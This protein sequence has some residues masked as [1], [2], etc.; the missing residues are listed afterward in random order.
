MDDP[1]KVIIEPVITEKST[2]TIEEENAQ[3]I[4]RNAYT[5]KVVRQATKPEIRE[6]VEAIFGVRVTSVNTMW[7]RGKPRRTRQGK[8]TRT[9]DWKKAIVKLQQGDRIELY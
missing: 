4:P 3:G 8:T 9:P 5:F 6:A 7:Q 2:E 1:R